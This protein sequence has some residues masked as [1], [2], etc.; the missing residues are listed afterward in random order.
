MSTKQL[1]ISAIVFITL[2]IL[3]ALCTT[4]GC[5][6]RDREW[7]LKST[8]HQIEI[9]NRENRLGNISESYNKNPPKPFRDI[10]RHINNFDPPM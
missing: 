8:P 3:I 4:P 9:D 7:T 5:V 6:S 1:L 10:V 2:A